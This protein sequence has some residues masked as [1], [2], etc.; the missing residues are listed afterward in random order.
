MQDTIFSTS[1]ALRWSRFAL[2]AVA[3][4][5]LSACANF[6]GIFSQAKPVAAQQAGLST[7]TIPADSVAL[8]SQWWKAYGD[9]Q[10]NQ[11]V[12]QALAN[13]P[14]LRVAQ[15]RVQR[16]QAGIDNANAASAP[17]LNAATS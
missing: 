17:Q 12:A 4:A 5:S 8:D 15:A 1:Q 7:Q 3:I 16:V 13:N 14:N 9:E 2:S 11:L 10:L 6:S